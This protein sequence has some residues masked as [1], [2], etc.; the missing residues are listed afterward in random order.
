MVVVL[1]I[2]LYWVY[3]S[4]HITVGYFSITACPQSILFLYHSILCTLTNVRFIKEQHCFIHI[5]SHNH[6]GFFFFTKCN[7]SQLNISLPPFLSKWSAER[8]RNRENVAENRP[9]S[10]WRRSWNAA[11]RAREN[12]EP[13]RSCATSTWRTWCPAKR[14]PSVPWG[15]N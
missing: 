12:V 13:G 14:E 2:W 7:I 1:Y 6:T 15:K 11:G 4:D 3:F 10:T 9:R 8:W 5:L